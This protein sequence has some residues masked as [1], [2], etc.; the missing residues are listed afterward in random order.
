MRTA[1]YLFRGTAALLAAATVALSTAGLLAI[2]ATALKQTEDNLR[3]AAGALVR[4]LDAAERSGIAIDARTARVALA[5]AGKSPGI[6]VTLIA[7]DGAVIA[8]SSAPADR[9]ENHIA[10]PEVAEALA[11]REGVAVRRSDTL[12]AELVYLALPYRGGALRL[13]VSVEY[14]RL[15]ARRFALGLLAVSL[16]TLA[17][18][19]AAASV[20]A[21]GITRP[22]ERLDAATRAWATGTG[23]PAKTGPEDESILPPESA[24]TVELAEL[25]RAFAAMSRNLRERMSELDARNRETE[26]ILAGMSDALIVFAESGT[27]LRANTAAGRLFGI[28]PEQA[29]GMD[30]LRLVRN[31]EIADAARAGEADA[32][33]MTV[34]LRDERTGEMRTLRLRLGAVDS[35]ARLLV[36]T[37]VTRLSRLERIRRDFVANVS[38]ELKTPITSIQGFIET[39]RDGAIDDRETAARF[40]S[41]ME[42]QSRRLTAI[43]DDLLTI[44]RLEREG[45]EPIERAQT[46]VESLIAGVVE[47]CA[48][49]ASK[50]GTSISLDIPVGLIVRLNP[51]LMEQAVANLLQNAIAY[52]RE[53]GHVE[54]SARVIEGAEGQ[55]DFEISVS[56]DGPGIPSRDLARVFER[57]YRVDRGRTRDRGGTGLGLS[58]VRHI[59]LAHGGEASARSVEGE[60]SVFTIR[61]PDGAPG[62][63]LL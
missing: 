42:G 52:G 11:G 62:G 17:I 2:R 24:P 18:A 55:R 32:E 46:S 49:A 61:I 30:L 53:G 41:I 33:G 51:G 57:F 16:A 47:L 63:F 12:H 10:R 9:L 54:I 44:S 58:I 23:S 36:L 60:G 29:R 37:D 5:E 19:F 6:R 31:T 27:V 8:D 28:E 4:A 3:H 43:I 14:A 48:D 26:A 45:G 25:E 38:H 1:S 21:R 50:R 20:L 59:A 34:E 22:L 13:A 15:A 56:D 7:P 35:G 39:L 40:L